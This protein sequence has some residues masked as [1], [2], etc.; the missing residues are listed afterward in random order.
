MKVI[1]LSKAFPVYH[2]RASEPTGFRQA[3]LEGRKIH[4]IRANKKGYLK[5]G[6]V[7]SIRQWS[8]KPYASKQEVIKD[9]VKIGV[10]PVTM[11]VFCGIRNANINGAT[12]AMEDL[13]FSD[14][15]P[16]SDFVD[17]FFYDDIND[18]FT[19][20]I[21]HFTDFRYAEVERREG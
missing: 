17:W 9:G 7:V 12:V 8:G 3:F 19:G 5:D 15:L 21:I 1:T 14:G 16:M 4:T 18:I 11:S 10:E 13:A 20:S 6:D 2:Q